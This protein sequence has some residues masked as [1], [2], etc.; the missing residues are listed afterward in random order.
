MPQPI[1]AVILANVA[2]A[3][4]STKLVFRMKEKRFFIC[5]SPSFVVNYLVREVYHIISEKYDKMRE[6]RD[7]RRK[8]KQGVIHVA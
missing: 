4:N 2:N 6:M 7:K 5:I 1:C 3:D 8:M